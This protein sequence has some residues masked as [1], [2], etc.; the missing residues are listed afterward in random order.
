M[1]PIARR[2]RRLMRSA[3][4]A[5][6]VVMGFLSVT[7]SATHVSFERGDIFLSLESGPVQWRLG[8]GTLWRL[9]LG[10]VP[11]TGEGMAFDPSGNLYVSRWCI[12]PWCSTGS[13]VEMYDVLGRSWGSVGTGYNCNPHALVFDA[14]NVAFVGQAGC[15]GSILKFVPGEIEPRQFAAAWDNQGSFWVDLGL[16][17]CTVF[18]TSWGSNV[19]RFDTC[20]GEQRPDFNAE[21]IG[22]GQAQDLRVLPDGGVIVSAGPQIVRLDQNGIVAQAYSVPEA[23]YWAGLDLAGDGT[24]F[25]AANYE[26]SNV[27]RFDLATG[28]IISSFSAGTP[29]HSVV[30]VRIAR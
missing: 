10:T 28:A 16:D 1:S 11:G 21:P 30:G 15:T 29:P 6:V 20:L 24:S 17:G 18:Y 14:G 4:L 2:P 23:A 12:D 8:D 25:W 7:I 3:V 9:L 22:G 26:T 19:K 5:G 27:Y 13:T